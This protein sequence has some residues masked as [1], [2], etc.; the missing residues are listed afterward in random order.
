MKQSFVVVTTKLKGTHLSS[1]VLGS[2][3]YN[4]IVGSAVKVLQLATSLA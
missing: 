2:S 3:Q 4:R 1:A